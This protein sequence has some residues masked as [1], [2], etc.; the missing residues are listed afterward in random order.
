MK[1]AGKWIEPEDII[2]SEVTQTQKD[3]QEGDFEKL[4]P[5]FLGNEEERG[6]GTGEGRELKQPSGCDVPGHISHDWGYRSLRKQ[7]IDDTL[8][9]HKAQILPDEGSALWAL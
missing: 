5:R 2:L 4:P 7:A 6:V 1:F 8:D 3:K 9:P